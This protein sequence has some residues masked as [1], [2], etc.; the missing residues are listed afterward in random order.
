[1]VFPVY[2]TLLGLLVVTL[3]SLVITSNYFFS[4]TLNID[5]KFLDEFLD[6][7]YRLPGALNGKFFP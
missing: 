5:T 2:F 1:M 4:F 7:V 6:K 3:K